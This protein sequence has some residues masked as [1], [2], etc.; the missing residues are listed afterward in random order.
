[1]SHW[2]Q[3]DQQYIMSTV[4]RL[5]LAIDR[6]KGN[7]LYDTHGTRYLDLFTG[8]A[9]NVL[10]HSHPRVMKALDEQGH[11]FLHIS[12]LFL[13][14]PAIQLA[15]RLVKNSLGQGKV[16]FCNSGAESTEAAIKLIFKWTVKE[17]HGKSGIVVIRN[18][19]HGRT[20]GAMRLTRQP[21]VY[22]DYPQLDFPVYE[23]DAYST[24]ELR[25]VCELHQPAAVLV[26][27]ILGAG[28]VVS[29]SKEF[30]HTVQTLCTQHQMLFCVDEIQTGMGRTGTLFAYQGLGLQPDLI[31]FAKG[32]GG[33][34]PLG[35]IISNEKTAHIFQPGDHGTTFAPS[36]L[37]AAMGNAVLD[38]LLDDG[39]L[40]Q[41]NQIAQELWKNLNRLQETYPQVI[42]DMDG[43]GMM[44]GIRTHCTQEQVA[45]LQ[46]TLMKKGILVNVTAKTV[47]RLLPPLT[48]TT[49]EIHFFT[50]SLEEYIQEYLLS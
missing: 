42:D 50:H 26:E 13:N 17:N 27:P 29:L 49:D 33:G 31:L 38:A 12:N 40:E 19:F 6:A 23:V 8:L 39:V 36:P 48:L 22:Q 35:G 14:P 11:R 47:I 34:L 45:H 46:H 7:Y 25:Q 44:I 1:M 28:G 37:S 10:G 3:L 21:S 4:K 18:S 43:R 16:Y 30:L 5:P 32:V 20:L 9:V 24:D 41:G 15:E 2:N